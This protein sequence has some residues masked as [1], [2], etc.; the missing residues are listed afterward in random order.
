MNLIGSTIFHTDCLGDSIISAKIGNSVY[1]SNSFISG[2]GFEFSRNFN[3]LPELKIVPYLNIMPGYAF[4]PAGTAGFQ[5]SF[6]NSEHPADKYIFCSV[7]R[8]MPDKKK[9]VFCKK[10]L[11]NL[12]AVFNH[13]A[14]T[15]Y[16]Y[17]I[18]SDT[19]YALHQRRYGFDIEVTG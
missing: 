13:F 1:F 6:F 15:A 12:R 3:F 17:K 8:R 7:V 5:Y 18:S 9:L 16:F 2:Y 19:R 14:N 4:L 11:Q 10:P